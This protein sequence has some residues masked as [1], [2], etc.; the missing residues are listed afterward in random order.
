MRVWAA[1]IESVDGSADSLG[2]GRGEGAGSP[3]LAPLV[4]V[5]SDSAV[6]EMT[7]GAVAD[8]TFDEETPVV[9]EVIVITVGAVEEAVVVDTIEAPGCLFPPSLLLFA[10]LG[11][12]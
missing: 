2:V 10:L 4:V 11:L 8:P 5:V 6:G 1:A 7:G 12:R 3:E 9:V